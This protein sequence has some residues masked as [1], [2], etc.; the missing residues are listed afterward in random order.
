MEF[1]CWQGTMHVSG[2]VVSRVH[3]KDETVSLINFSRRVSETYGCGA[4]TNV[5]ASIFNTFD[6]TL[7]SNI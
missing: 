2:V 7:L 6:L 1:S 5:I 3:D 4:L